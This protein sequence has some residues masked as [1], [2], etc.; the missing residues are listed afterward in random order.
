MAVLFSVV[1]H[2]Q[3]P[4]LTQVDVGGVIQTIALTDSIS[5]ELE[6]T[7]S[8]FIL[9]G[10]VIQARARCEKLRGQLEPLNKATYYRAI[11]ELAQAK[12]TLYEYLAKSDPANYAYTYEAKKYDRTVTAY[13]KMLDRMQ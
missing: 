13:A 8:L 11:K 6:K 7:D 5:A 9:K 12:C 1:S 10:H 4:A 3:V 2:A